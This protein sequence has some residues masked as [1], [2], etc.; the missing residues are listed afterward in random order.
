MSVISKL[1]RNPQGTWILEDFITFGTCRHFAVVS[2]HIMCQLHAH[3]RLQEY[4]LVSSQCF[5]MC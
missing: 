1:G 3:C 2:C 5:S 4:Q